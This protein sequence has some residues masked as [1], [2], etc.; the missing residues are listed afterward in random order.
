MLSRVDYGKIMDVFHDRFKDFSDFRFYIAGDF[1]SDS[2]KNLVKR[3]VASLPAGGR[4]ERS[5]DIGSVSYTHLH[6]VSWKYLTLEIV[7]PRWSTPVVIGC[8]DVDRMRIAPFVCISD[9][10]MSPSVVAF[11]VCP[12]GV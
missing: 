6:R 7:V 5:Q 11:V 4:M 2:V 12:L 1:D 3:Y 8:H 9:L 10:G